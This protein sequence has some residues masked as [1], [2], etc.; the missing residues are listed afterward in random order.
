MERRGTYRGREE[1]QEIEHTH[2]SKVMK[3]GF[4]NMDLLTSLTDS[5]QPIIALTHMHPL[6]LLVQR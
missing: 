2:L 4:I 3:R 6:V 1:E 5:S